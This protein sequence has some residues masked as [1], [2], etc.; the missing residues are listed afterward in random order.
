VTGIYAKFGHVHAQHLMGD[1][2]LHGKGVKMDEIL[3]ME[4]F[5]KAAEQ[6]HPH[7][8]YN[9]A[10][11]HLNGLQTGLQPGSTHCGDLNQARLIN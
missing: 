3:A 6:G 4:W 8:A 7:S 5:K 11:G 1:K 2:Y 9:L 10:I